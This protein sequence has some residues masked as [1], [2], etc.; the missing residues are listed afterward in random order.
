MH[1]PEP[2]NPEHVV[3]EVF[4]D[5]NMAAVVRR[6]NEVRRGRTRWSEASRAVLRHLE[7]VGFAQAPRYLGSEGETERFSFVPGETPG[8][9]LAGYRDDAILSQVGTMIRAYHDAMSSFVP[10]AGVKW[11][12][13]PGTPESDG[14]QGVICH[15]DIAPWN[16][17]CEDGQLKAL[18]DW[19]LVA[20][21]TRAWD[22]AY[23][24]WRFAPLYP[25]EAFGSPNERVRRIHL[26]LDAYGMAVDDRRGF[27]E[28]I[29]ARMQ[30]AYDTVEEWGAS[31]VPGFER[32]YRLGLH[33]DAL[34]H[35]AWTRASIV[36]VW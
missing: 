21:A 2:F 36:P 29:L 18:I 17:V 20:P 14:T 19:D 12:I 6:G 22:L 1:D 9:D 27:P 32:L 30:A 10:P 31:G 33:R 4:A 11:P 34:E 26:L 7:A 24:A 23:A 28:I 8:A 15:N 5:G 25:D 35:I 3:D 13:A 16:V